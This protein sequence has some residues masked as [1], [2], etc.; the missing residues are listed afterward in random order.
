[1]AASAQ[2]P[3]LPVAKAHT[4]AA[5]PS[6]YSAGQLLLTLCRRIDFLAAVVAGALAMAMVYYL[7]VIQVTTVHTIATR[8]ATA[9]VYQAGLLVLVPA[10]VLLFGMNFGLTVLLL[11]ARAAAPDQ[12][13]SLVGALIGG[14]GASCPSCSAFLLSLIGVSAGLSV[15]PFAGLELWIAAAL[16]MAFTLWRSLQALSRASC[17]VRAGDGQC[18][19]LPPVSIA[20]A[21][22][23]AAANL[24]LAG[25][26]T[27]V[28]SLHEPR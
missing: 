22:V 19:G 16:V 20:Q 25:T 3:D 24:V 27:V 8:T 4:S 10:A 28:I 17:A 9:P 6:E 18:V 13:G 12:A 21:T 23:F 11:R 14:F 1:M 26:L 5:P 7:L 15:L 2:P